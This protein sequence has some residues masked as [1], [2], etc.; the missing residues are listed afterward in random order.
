MHPVLAAD[1]DAVAAHSSV[2]DGAWKLAWTLQEVQAHTT[3]IM[4]FVFPAFT[5]SPFSSIASF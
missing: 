4:I 2:T 5:L 1:A 3:Q